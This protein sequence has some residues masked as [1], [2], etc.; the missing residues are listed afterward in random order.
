MITPQREGE[1]GK[2]KSTSIV[3]LGLDNI[4]IVLVALVIEYSVLLTYQSTWSIEDDSKFLKRQKP[5]V[6]KLT[7]PE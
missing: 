6:T 5:K 2:M 7:L 1:R 3:S 4:D